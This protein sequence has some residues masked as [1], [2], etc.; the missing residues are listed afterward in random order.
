MALE[1]MSDSHGGHGTH[2][3]SHG[4]G[5]GAAGNHELDQRILQLPSIFEI[6]EVVHAN[7]GEE[8]IQVADTVSA[9][10]ALYEKL[11]NV[12]E[13]EEEHRLRRNAIRR[14]LKRRIGVDVESQQLAKDVLT[15][16]IW[17]RYLPN[18]TI[19]IAV[20][21]TVAE[22]LVKYNPLVAALSRSSNPSLAFDFILD[23]MAIE[24][25][26]HVAPPTREDALASFAYRILQE[27][28]EWKK[29]SL[30]EDERELQLYLAVYRT[31]LKADAA[32]LRSRVFLLYYPHWK[33]GHA[34]EEIAADLDAIIATVDG[35]IKHP[36]AERLSREVRKFAVLFNVLF[37][38]V[39]K[40]PHEF[41]SAVSTPAE[42]D[43][44]VGKAAAARIKTFQ[45]RKARRVF[46][47]VAFL[48]VTKMML[49]LVIELPYDLVIAHE[50]SLFPLAVNIIFPPLL[51][52]FIAL[53]AR[54]NI[55]LHVKTIQKGVRSI[56]FGTQELNMIFK[57]TK[58]WN[59]A[60]T[61]TFGLLY[62]LSFFVV[63]GF[64]GSLLIGF[65]FNIV[66]MSIFLLFLTLVT[67]FGLQIRQSIKE[68]VV[69]KNRSG[70]VGALIDWFMLPIVR[71]GRWISIRTPRINVFIFF[72]DFIIEAPFK[73]AI[74][75]IEGWM[76][77]VREK[78]EELE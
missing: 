19:P 15:E 10:A 56:A 14:V 24:V 38:V 46:R 33:I 20:I 48:F 21:D 63:F 13:Y 36:I 31:L 2:G 74:E 44:L 73:L 37:D 67:F 77:F 28:I 78:K 11:R 5:H 76:A 62:T 53:T 69:D 42:L 34:N 9:A 18:N 57:V 27:K 60:F 41:L 39:A 29:G 70:I 43:K 4:G 40:D 51:L 49:A 25:E 1:F 71:V 32:R 75:V 66:S 50:T 72:M 54:L 30:P 55:K 3:A 45:S 6:D 17:A 12:L 35:Q 64:I 23:L 7:E 65:G 52:A 16:L 47:A 68:V 22:A 8:A 26:S 58:G 61:W 59:Q